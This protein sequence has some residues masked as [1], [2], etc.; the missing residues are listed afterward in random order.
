MKTLVLVAAERR[1]FL[2]IEPHL[3]RLERLRWPL[4]YCCAGVLADRRLLL[5]ANGAGKRLALDA[6]EMAGRRAEVSAVISTGFC[7]GLDPAL[8]AGEIFVAHQVRGPDSECYPAVVPQC[9]RPYRS[10]VLLSQ[11]C[12]VR[13]WQDKRDLYESGAHAVDMESAALAGRASAWG[14]PFYAIRAVTDTA[15]ESFGCDLEGARLPDGRISSGRLLLAAL[16]EPAA[17]LPELWHL[18]RRAKVAA[19][20]L[21]EFLADCRF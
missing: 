4:D 11:D 12:I 18:R 3:A 13:T 16:R 14:L 1:E 20:A 5:V 15:E 17:R 10:G 21:G 6:L 9:P 8:A 2:G 7:G 19:E